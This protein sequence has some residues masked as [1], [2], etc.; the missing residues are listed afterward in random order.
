MLAGNWISGSKERDGIAHSLGYLSSTEL[1]QMRL[2]LLQIGRLVSG[3]ACTVK[4]A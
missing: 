3:E 1:Q 4:I 2:V